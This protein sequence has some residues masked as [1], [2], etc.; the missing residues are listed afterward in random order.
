MKMNN[1]LLNDTVLPP[2]TPVDVKC[3][4][5]QVKVSV[6]GRQYTFSTKPFIS[7][8]VTRDSQILAAPIHLGVI[9]DNEEVK[10]ES[11]KPVLKLSKSS[12]AVILQK[13]K[14]TEIT[15]S[16]KT[17]VEFD[18]F[19]RIDWN[20]TPRKP[21]KIQ[22]LTI[23]IPLKAENA[24]YLNTWPT[25][26]SDRGYFNLGYSGALTED[27][28]SPFKPIIW[29]GDNQRGISW[30]AETD[31]YWL[32]AVDDKAIEVIKNDKK[33]I[34][35]L[36]IIGKQ[37]T[38]TPDKPLCYSFA[39]QATPLKNIDKDCWDWR[40]AAFYRPYESMENI[41]GGKP[42]LQ[43]YKENSIKTGIIFVWF[44]DLFCQPWPVG[45]EKDFKNLVDNMHA[46]GLKAIVYLGH[47]IDQRSPQY[48]IKMIRVPEI[49]N[50]FSPDPVFDDEIFDFR[51]KPDAKRVQVSHVCLNSAWQNK[52]VEGVGKMINDFDIDGVY[53]DTTNLPFDCR[54][55]SHGCGYRRADGSLAPTHPIFA[56]R[57]T[58]K[59][60]YAAIKNK[61]P[62][63]IVDIHVFDCMNGAALAYATSYWNGEQL[64]RNPDYPEELTLDRFRTEMMGVNWGIPCDFLSY[65]FGSYYEAFAYSLLHDVLVRSEDT[66]TGDLYLL[67]ARIIRLANDFGRKKAQFLPYWNNQEYI[68]IDKKDWH[69]SAYKHPDNGILI[70]ISNLSKTGDLAKITVNLEKFGLLKEKLEVIDGLS[71]TR[72]AFKN[73]VIELKLP[74]KGWRYIWLKKE[75]L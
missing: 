58:I 74:P 46:L 26:W 16:F 71:R 7:N 17:E 44:T 38:V 64:N 45:H 29:L 72:I 53:L 27:Y 56:V 52:L 24:I 10:W 66:K 33:V 8:I 40:F 23:E 31:Q 41:Y 69:A 18:G 5:E 21:V 49:I 42:I 50:E 47:M 22:N 11:I 32:P 35:R 30:Y 65:T 34:L 12:R 13:L 57:E 51:R 70:I 37:I 61:K 2:Y 4:S 48:G 54:N 28:S 68:G 15:A 3:S 55:E 1:C 36:N 6:L 39:F 14:S 25:R 63:G 75:K 19:A 20:L 62:D 43:L 67:A 73:N 60:I 9:I 59:R